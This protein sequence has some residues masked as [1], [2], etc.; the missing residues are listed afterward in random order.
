MGCLVKVHIPKPKEVRFW[1]KIIDCIFIKY[2]NNS[3][4]NK[5][6]VH[7]SE[8]LDAYE[9]TIIKLMNVAFFED[10]FSC[11]IL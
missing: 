9:G 11:T 5:F 7:K 10:I 6:L 2:A 3:S 8:I 1:S 4:A